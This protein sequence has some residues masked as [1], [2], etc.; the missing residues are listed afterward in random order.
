MRL[1]NNILILGRVSNLPTIWTNCL[2]AWV[3][4]RYASS[5]LLELG[6]Y[7]EATL[8]PWQTL[9]WLLLGASLLYLAGCTLNDAFDQKFDELHNPHRPIPSGDMTAR[10]VWLVGFIE[11]GL[12]IF[13]LVKLSG[14]DWVWLTILAT[15]IILYDAIHKKWVGS[16]WLMGSCRFFLWLT[17]AS[18]ANEQLAPL[19]VGW[20]T[21]VGLYVVGISLFARAEST[22]GPGRNLLAIPMLYGP[23]A[24]ALFMILTAT[25]H[26]EPQ[27][28]L[29]CMV[30]ALVAAR[31]AT[32]S[33]KRMRSRQPGCIGKGVSLLLAGIAACDATA[34]GMLLPVAGWGCLAGVPIALALQKKFAAT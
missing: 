15:V 25:P 18:A 28:M 16:V 8:P 12:G 30:G 13:V 20:S 23:L 3:V 14:V 1:L 27:A 24:Y 31:L 17:A 10:S 32:F 4:N 21:V 34:A 19:T 26:P 5:D 29:A 11:M 7:S 9:G 2:A 6:V 22:G 33:M